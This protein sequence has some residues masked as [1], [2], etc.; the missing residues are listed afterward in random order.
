MGILDNIGETKVDYF[1]LHCNTG[2][3]LDY[4]F[5]RYYQGVDK[6]WYNNGG[7]SW[8]PGI[9]G[10]SQRYKSHTAYAYVA[11]A[12]QLFPESETLLMDTENSLESTEILS[13]IANTDLSGRTKLLTNVTHDLDS[14]LVEFNKIVANKIAHKKDYMV[15]YPFPNPKDPS[16][17]FKYWIPTFVVI[18]SLSCLESNDNIELIMKNGIS[19]NKNN[20]YYFSDGKKKCMLLKVLSRFGSKY[21]IYTV[22]TAHVTDVANLDMYS[23]NTK[24]LEYMDKDTKAK[25]VGNQ[26]DFC[27]TMQIYN[28]KSTPILDSSRKDTFYTIQDEVVG[29]KNDIVEVQSI[30]TRGKQGVGG[31]ASFT[32]VI[33]QSGGYQALLTA[34]NYL[35]KNK[36]VGLEGTDRSP[37]SPLMP[38]VN[39]GRT[40]VRSYID[41]DLE[42]PITRALNITAGYD[43]MK[44]NWTPELRPVDMP[45]STDEFVEKLSALPTSTLNEIL[46]TRGE[47]SYKGAP[48]ERTYL[49]LPDIVKLVK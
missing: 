35:R 17:C 16:K 8:M 32:T 44:T 10:R 34:H 43:Y 27:T 39:L 41:T 26:F 40:K 28:K 2:T 33:S 12:M 21:G 9:V 18:D 13:R 19:S 6:R 14:F 45:Y 7:L 30:I 5:G 29:N 1:K 23:P 31:G 38:E 15:E 36:Y 49:S 46:A 24:S 20:T 48:T 11:K 22:L 42:Y 3:P 25:S 37:H 4:A 47:W